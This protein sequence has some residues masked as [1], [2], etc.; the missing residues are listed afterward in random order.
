MLLVAIFFS[1]AAAFAVSLFLALKHKVAHWTSL[2]LS[3]PLAAI[4]VV[5]IT[6]VFTPWLLNLPFHHCPFCLFFEHPL[7]ILFTALLW[8]ALAS[9]W[10]LLITSRLGK[11]NDESKTYEVSLKRTILTYSSIAMLVSLGI[12]AA[13]ILV[14]LL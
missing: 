3:I 8:F 12:I 10:L 7:S 5:T 13:D 9:P 1:V 14:T 4:F 6:E 2:A 11:E